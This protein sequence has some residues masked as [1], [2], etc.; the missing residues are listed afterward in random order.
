M[1]RVVGI[2]V[3]IAGV[4]LGAVMPVFA[5]SRPIKQ[6]PSDVVRW[7]TMWVAVPQEMYAVGLEEGPL[8]AVTWGP[9]KGTVT[10]VKSTTQEFWDVVKPDEKPGHRA[11]TRRD[12]GLIARYEF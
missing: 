10:F 9:A 8:A 4:W 6:L 5:E 2:G 3:L 12:T 11:P 7:S 1:T